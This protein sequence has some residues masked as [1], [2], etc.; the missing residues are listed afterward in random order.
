MGL[1]GKR[2][3]DRKSSGWFKDVITGIYT[4]DQIA[5][6]WESVTPV[7]RLK[8]VA[9]WVPREMKVDNNSTFQLIIKGL[10]NKVIESKVIENL[11]LDEHPGDDTE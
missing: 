7:D 1:R 8:I 5:A 3:K 10:E 2:G 9:A 11:A 6:D 4:S